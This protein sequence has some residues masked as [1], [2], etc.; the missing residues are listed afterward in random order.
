MEATTTPEDY[1]RFDVARAI[2]FYT[3]PARIPGPAVLSPTSDWGALSAAR[4]AGK[5]EPMESVAARIEYPGPGRE[6][7][8]DIYLDFTYAESAAGPLFDECRSIDEVSL[9]LPV[10]LWRFWVAGQDGKEVEICFRAVLPRMVARHSTTRP[11]G[12]LGTFTV[13]DAQP[14]VEVQGGG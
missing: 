13:L 14:F 7:L 10:Y 3:D 11:G 9:E 4:S 1:R 12:L 2:E 8:P 6:G 5:R